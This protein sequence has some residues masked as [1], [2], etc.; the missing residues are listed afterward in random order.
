[1]DA[2]RVMLGAR[3]H[4]PLH[5]PLASGEG[6][7]RLGIGVKAIDFVEVGWGNGFGKEAGSR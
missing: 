6:L 4:Y 7:H 2:V 5:A 3:R 1:M